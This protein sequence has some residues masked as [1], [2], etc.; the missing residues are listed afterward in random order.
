[1]NWLECDDEVKMF[2]FFEKINEIDVLR[3]FSLEMSCSIASLLTDQSL[4]DAIAVAQEFVRGACGHKE[5]TK[6]YYDVQKTLHKIVENLPPNVDDWDEEIEK[7]LNAA[8]VVAW[9]VLPPN[10]D[11]SKKH[12]KVARESAHHAAYYSYQI[13]PNVRELRRQEKVMKAVGLIG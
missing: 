3:K 5:L 9:A 2:G 8:Q 10:I 1:M 7:S 13:N 11:G 4:V 12:L 6:T